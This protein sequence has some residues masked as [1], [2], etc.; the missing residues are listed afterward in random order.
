MPT[1]NRFQVLG[2]DCLAIM[3]QTSLRGQQGG[4]AKAP[5]HNS[6]DDQR[7]H[8]HSHSRRGQHMQSGSSSQIG[9]QTPN[10][11]GSSGH[12]IE[13]NNTPRMPQPTPLFERLVTEEVQELKAYAR[14]IENQNRRL[15]ELERVHGDL[16]TR[17]EQESR[18][19]VQLERT[20]EERER[21]WALKFKELEVDRD[22]W[23]GVVKVEQTKNARLIDQVVRK[24]QDIHRMLQRKVRVCYGCGAP[25]TFLSIVDHHLVVP[26]I[27]MIIKGSL[28][29]HTPFEIYGTR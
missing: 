25:M 9:N 28:L 8:V 24:D 16:E 23:K 4:D 20:L 14:I 6:H 5:Q 26:F 13:S 22:H 21:G 7:F 11:N 15:A 19:N 18:G 17:L 2:G 10:R 29:A 3:A 1:K 12:Y 27:S